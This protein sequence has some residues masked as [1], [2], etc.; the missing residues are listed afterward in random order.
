MTREE[1][2]SNLQQYKPHNVMLEL[3]TGFGKTFIALYYAVNIL[4]C[5]KILVVSPTHAII[6]NWKKEIEKFKYDSS[7]FNFITYVSFLD[8]C[9]HKYKNYDCYIYDEVHHLSDRCINIILKDKNYYNSKRNILL[10]ATVDTEKRNA[11]KQCFDRIFIHKEYLKNTINDG[12]L[13]SPTCVLIPLTLPKQYIDDYNALVYTIN[14][15]KHQYDIERKEWQQTMWLKSCGDLLKFLASCKTD[16]LK[17]IRFIYRAK[18]M[19]IFCKDIEQTQVMGNPVNSKDKKDENLQRFNDKKIMWISACSMLNEG[20][21]LTSCQVGLF[22][23]LNSNSRVIYQKMGRLLR[24]KQP[25]FFIP[26]YANTREAT[27]VN[28]MIQMCFVPEKTKV[29]K[30]EE[31]R[32]L[33]RYEYEKRK[34]K[35]NQYVKFKE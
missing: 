21:T 10:S 33:Q 1:I 11:I 15:Y 8:E 28:K 20:V 7:V 16:I 14:Q 18:R 32:I 27:I 34:A 9:K 31:N 2:I 25:V 5:K 23:F 19:L 3:P 12:K 6:D 13:P 29:F 26:Y 22:A 4:H 35:N 24:H 17:K 30:V